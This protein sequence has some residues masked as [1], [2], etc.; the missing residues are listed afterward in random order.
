MD[1]A[2][3]C[4]E[5]LSC[6][7]LNSFVLVVRVDDE[8]LIYLIERCYNVLLQLELWQLYLLNVHFLLEIVHCEDN[9]IG[10]L[11]DAFLF[12]L[13]DDSAF[14]EKND[15]YPAGYHILN[16]RRLKSCELLEHHRRSAGLIP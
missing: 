16:G 5:C 13:N 15:L 3:F 9:V 6:D 1:I 7:V 14:S 11:H 8:K 10:V 12:N 2:I 4:E